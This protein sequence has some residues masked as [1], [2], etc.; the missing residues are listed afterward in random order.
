[1]EEK[2]ESILDSCPTP[3]KE[4]IL[5]LETQIKHKISKWYKIFGVNLILV[6]LVTVFLFLSHTSII[7]I[8]IWLII[9][10]PLFLGSI[11]VILIRLYLDKNRIHDFILLKVSKNLIR[12]NIKTKRG[13][14]IRKYYRVLSFEF[15]WNGGIYLI[16]EEAVWMDED[17]IP[18]LDYF[19]G[20]PNPLIYDFETVLHNYNISTDKESFIDK[21][22]NIVDVSYSSHTLKQFKKDKLF[23][24]LHSSGTEGIMQ[25]FVVFMVAICVILLLIM[26][27]RK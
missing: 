24:E 22:G 19:E 5:S 11:L 27:F 25:M 6:T 7:W 9:G 15:E 2:K 16:D 4:K 8:V 18:N 21:K 14:V 10:I 3:Q 12:A 13:K 1:M 20:I 26:I 17:N 23:A